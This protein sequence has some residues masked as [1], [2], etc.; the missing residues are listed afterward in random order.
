MLDAI[1]FDLDGTLLPM[2]N[3]EFTKGYLSLLARAVAP[4]GYAADTMIPAMWQGVAAM[5]K[6]D[7]TRRNC[8]V[9]WQI[10][11]DL[12]S[13]DVTADI[14]HFDAFYSDGFH[15]AKAYKIGRASCRERVCLSV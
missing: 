9:F 6:N 3:D 5:V 12:L 14:P 7:G 2:D 10:F 13:R 15:K 4:Y 8:E 1:L 11:S